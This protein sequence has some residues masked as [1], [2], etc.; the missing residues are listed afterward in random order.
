MMLCQSG[1]FCD[2]GYILS[3]KDGECISE[4]ECENMTTDIPE[5]GTGTTGIHAFILLCRIMM[6][7][8]CSILFLCIHKWLII[9]LVIYIDID[10]ECGDN[11]HYEDCGTGCP[12]ICGDSSPVMCTA[13][14]EPGCFCDRGYILSEE[15]GECIT[16]DECENMTTDIPQGTGTTNGTGIHTFILLCAIMMVSLHSII[17]FIYI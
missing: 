8:L 1:C 4:E 12:K 9:I 14:C 17:V 15:D 3:E 6:V 16:E 13:M 11:E 5:E 10:R 2:R 7:S